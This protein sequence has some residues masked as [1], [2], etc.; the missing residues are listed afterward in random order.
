MNENH[1]F[2]N[3]TPTNFLVYLLFERFLKEVENV[4]EKSHDGR[5]VSLDLDD[6]YLSYVS[7]RLTS[8]KEVVSDV[9]FTALDWSELA[10]R[11]QLKLAKCKLSEIFIKNIVSR[12]HV[13]NL[14]ITLLNLSKVIESINEL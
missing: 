4:I 7:T 13:D 8:T 10:I 2:K 5:C 3:V 1:V 6:S 12:R 14:F 11:E 9:S